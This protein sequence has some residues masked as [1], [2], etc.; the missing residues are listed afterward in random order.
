MFLIALELE[1]G[2]RRGNPPIFCRK[3]KGGLRL[4]N[5]R[6][7]GRIEVWKMR[8]DGYGYER[9]PVSILNHQCYIPTG[10]GCRPVIWRL[11]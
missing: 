10:Y 4:H 9:P 8:E 7:D 3:G 5:G 2:I 11:S 6:F 1:A